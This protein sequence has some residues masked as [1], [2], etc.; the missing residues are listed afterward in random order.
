MLSPILR[1]DISPDT[2]SSLFPEKS[3]FTADNPFVKE[4]DN[5]F[6]S[7]IKKYVDSPVKPYVAVVDFNNDDY[8]NEDNRP[9][10]G[11]E[12]GLNFSF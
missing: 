10:Q 5:P 3:S 2:L 8:C 6:Y 4:P 7:F 12:I 9:K 1:D 11:I